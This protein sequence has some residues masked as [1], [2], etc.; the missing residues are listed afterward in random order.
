MTKVEL[1]THIGIERNPGLASFGF[2]FLSHTA[3]GAL[4]GYIEAYSFEQRIGDNVLENLE[5]T[6]LLADEPSW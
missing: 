6:R 2:A 5:L 1:G 4:G 3:V